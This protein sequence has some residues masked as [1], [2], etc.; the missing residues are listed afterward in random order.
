ML[1]LEYNA[2]TTVVNGSGQ[3]AKEATHDKEIR[4][5][6][7]GKPSVW[8]IVAKATA[9]APGRVTANPSVAEVLPEPLLVCCLFPH[10]G[11]YCCCGVVA[12]RSSLADVKGLNPS[13]GMAVTVWRAGAC[14]CDCTLLRRARVGL[15]MKLQ[16]I[17]TTHFPRGPTSKVPWPPE[18]Q[19]AA[20]DQMFR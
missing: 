12:D 2:D 15:L 20:G 9:A 8:F 18:T 16:A 7:E 1:L 11:S 6:L 4:N 10:S 13:H 14:E 19:P 5:M 17:S 3:T